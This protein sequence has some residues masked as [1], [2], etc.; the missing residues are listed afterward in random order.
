MLQIKMQ[1]DKPKIRMYKIVRNKSS[2]RLNELNFMLSL[3]YYVYQL[4]IVLW[5]NLNFFDVIVFCTQLKKDVTET[6]VHRDI[7]NTACKLNTFLFFYLRSH[8]NIAFN[9]HPLIILGNKDHY[10]TDFFECCC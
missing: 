5:L 4:S 6:N 7:R 1:S 10:T 9:V 3:L 8:F 2:D